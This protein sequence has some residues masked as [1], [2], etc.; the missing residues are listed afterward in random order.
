M[1]QL[2]TEKESCFSNTV[3]YTNDWKFEIGECNEEKDQCCIFNTDQIKHQSILPKLNPKKLFFPRIMFTTELEV[4]IVS[5]KSLGLNCIRIV[6]HPNYNKLLTA[7]LTYASNL[8]THETIFY[9]PY[10]LINQTWVIEK[11]NYSISNPEVKCGLLINRHN[12]TNEQQKLGTELVDY[13]CNEGSCLT[14]LKLLHLATSIHDLTEWKKK[15]DYYFGVKVGGGNCH[16]L[17]IYGTSILFPIVFNLF[18]NI[19][20]ILTRFTT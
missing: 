13:Y 14:H 12:R 15:T 18:F 9:F 20:S 8:S 1:R 19:L 17:R 11:I 4:W 10:S 16:L 5:G 3:R 2:E 7:H 6:T